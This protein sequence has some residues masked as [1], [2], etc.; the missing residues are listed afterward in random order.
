MI[1]RILCLL[2]SCLFLLFA[3]IRAGREQRI[4]DRLEQAQRIEA[5]EQQYAAGEIP[6]VDEASFYD[7]DLK[8]DLADG[9]RFNELSFAA[10]H[11]SYQTEALPE[12][13]KIYQNLSKLTFGLVKEQIG[14]FD[15]ETLTEQFN[16]GIRSIEMD[17][18]TEVKDGKISFLCMHVPVTNMT[19]NSYDF[20]LALKEI[21]M[22]SEN[23]PS[24][25]P[26]TIIIEPKKLTPPV[27][28]LKPFKLK[29]AQAL[30]ELLR[31]SLGDKLMTPAD[32][33]GDYESFEQMR[34]D[35]GWPQVRDMLGKVLV[36]LHDTT[37]TQ[38]YIKQDESIKSQAMFPMLRYNDRKR[39]C[40][41]FLLINSPDDALK[42]SEEIVDE[43]N[44]IMRTQADS[45]AYYSDKKLDKAI[46][47]RAQIL[48]TDY[49]MKAGET[50]E[51][52]FVY[53][54]DHKTVRKIK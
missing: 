14:G 42:H 37:V 38:K 27:N 54:G 44:L 26:V 15:S 33:L 12:L 24:H 43:Y 7:G 4:S 23:N 31:D 18:E 34:F 50:K 13:R 16:L 11:N 10:T 49:P 22:W 9:I 40:A 19:T 47:S 53:F 48:S 45:Y 39:D 25:L 2:L 51:T 3:D 35:N 21:Y 46:Q 29:Y 30:D 5:L 6:P 1:R 28:N 41:S 20:A 8:K 36:L 32:I 17:I 52:H